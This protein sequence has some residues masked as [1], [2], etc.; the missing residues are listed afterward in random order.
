M[1]YILFDGPQRA[2]LFPFT[3]TRPVADLRLG[4]L[5]IREKWEKY[6]NASTATLTEPHLT[7]KYPL[8]ECAE[9]TYING[10]FL[11][12]PSLVERIKNL[13]S[14]QLLVCD[15]HPVAFCGQ[16]F[17]LQRINS[18][19][20]IGCGDLGL[21][22]IQRNWHLFTHNDQAIRD[23]FELLTKGRKSREIDPSN[24]LLGPEDQ[25]FLEEG[26][27]VRGAFLNAECGPVYIGREA[28]VMAGALIRGPF[29]MGAHS[30]INMG[31][32]IY[33]ATG[34][35]P[36]VTLGGKVKNTT[37]FGY[38]NK[39]HEGYLG[40][41]VL[42]E[43][44]NLGAG[45]NNSNLKNDYGLVAVWNYALK[46]Y[47]QTGLQFCGL[48]MGDHSKCSIN[49]M[50]NTGAVVGVSSNLFGAGFHDKFIPSFRWGG[51]PKVS[52]RLNKAMDVAHR[53]MRRR[54]RRFTEADRQIFEY[55]FNAER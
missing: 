14:H 9:N 30:R 41:S 48:F 21:T 13:S 35:G 10:G 16:K 46:K 12:V 7:Q 52:Y 40:D 25:I 33:G 38:S 45:T 1:N 37:V 6:L 4:I 50:F 24:Q 23:D 19:Q 22:H 44:C 42:G 27:R 49:S 15:G 29:A 8:I 53:V 5:T 2:H 51:N 28:T 55:I 32:R 36:S 3:L 43:W 18:F 20:K 54:N 47:E 17:D 26:A 39:A 31:A 34:I 11:P